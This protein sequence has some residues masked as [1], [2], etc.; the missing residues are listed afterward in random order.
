MIKHKDLSPWQAG[1]LAKKFPSYDQVTTGNLEA[2]D[3]LVLTRTGDNT[4]VDASPV[5][6]A[7]IGAAIG[8]MPVLRRS[9]K[10]EAWYWLTTQEKTALLDLNLH[11]ETLVNKNFNVDDLTHEERRVIPERGGKAWLPEKC[12]ILRENSREMVQ[13]HH[14]INP[15]FTKMDYR[16]CVV[17]KERSQY[18]LGDAWR[19]MVRRCFDPALLKALEWVIYDLNG[20]GTRH[21]YLNCDLPGVNKESVM[22][23]VPY[24]Y[25][26]L[27]DWSIV[28]KFHDEVAVGYYRGT[29]FSQ[30][31]D[32]LKTWQERTAAATIC[33]E[34]KVLRAIVENKL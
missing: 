29:G 19:R 30:P 32:I 18:G 4:L 26:R 27:K 12:I 1:E 14:P 33:L 24:V 22:L 20:N 11:A 5:S 15:D 7:N 13:V 21:L 9:V 34:A 6:A 16:N 17:F 2:G 25:F 23:Y 8:N 3:L 10:S 28:E 31:E